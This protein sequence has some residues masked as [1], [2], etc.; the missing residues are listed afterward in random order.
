MTSNTASIT[1]TPDAFI[2]NGLTVPKMKRGQLNTYDP[3]LIK[4]IGV[5]LF[6]QLIGPKE[7]TPIPD[8][9]FSDAEWDDMEEQL[10][11]DR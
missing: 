1:E 4:A 5:D 6:F 9:G 11:D 3:A 8:L 2:V 10:R 7:Q